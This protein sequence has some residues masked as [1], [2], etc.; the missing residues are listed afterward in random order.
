[1]LYIFH[2]MTMGGRYNYQSNFRDGEMQDFKKL[3]IM[4]DDMENGRLWI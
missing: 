4:Q 2:E 1:M 3:S